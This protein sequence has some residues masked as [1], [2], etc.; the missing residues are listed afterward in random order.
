MDRPHLPR[1]IS[2]ANLE[3]TKKCTTHIERDLC[4]HYPRGTVNY[5]HNTPSFT[6]TIPSLRQY[7]KEFRDYV[8]RRLVDQ[9]L[10]EDLE[11]ENVINWCKDASTFIPLSTTGDGNCL[12]HAASLGMWGFQD[13]KFLLRRALRSALQNSKG[14]SLHARWVHWRQNEMK[15]FGFNLDKEEWIREW[16]NVIDNVSMET[17]GGVL[18]GLDQFHVF[19]LANVLRRP[20]IV[21]SLPK[22][23]SATEGITLQKLTFH[24]IYLPLLWD[25]RECKRIPLP[26]AFNGGHFVS[27]VA[28]D[29]AQQYKGGRLL[30]PLVEYTGVEFPVMFL[31]PDEKEWDVR[32]AYLNTNYLKNEIICVEMMLH[33]EPAYM[34]PLLSGFINKCLAAFQYEQSIVQT[35][36]A[37]ASNGGNSS[38]ANRPKCKN[39]CDFYGNPLLGGYCSVCHKKQSSSLSSSSAGLSLRC[40]NVGCT[41]KGQ[42]DLLG[43]CQ[44]CY[45]LK[46][47]GSSGDSA[48]KPGAQTAPVEDIRPCSNHGC[49]FIGTK[50]MSYYCSKCYKQRKGT[51]QDH[52][53]SK[54]PQTTYR[55]EF[56]SGIEDRRE[57][58]QSVSD[59]RNN[60]DKCHQCL[61]FYSSEEYSGL[62]HRCFIEKTRKDSDQRGN[63]IRCKK[64]SLPHDAVSGDL[65]NDCLKNQLD[66]ANIVSVSDPRNNPDKC[67]QCLEFYSSEEYSGLCHR[68]FIEKTR[69]DSDQRGNSIRC[70]KCSLPHDAVSGDLCNDCLK[71]Q[72]D[73]A[74]THPQGD[75]S[76]AGIREM[77]M[78]RQRDNNGNGYTPDHHYSDVPG[79]LQPNHTSPDPVSAQAPHPQSEL[80]QRRTSVSKGTCV[81]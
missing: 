60:P 16:D 68:C 79:H 31:L 63:S 77:D 61:E 74:K 66:A 17:K 38:A 78:T 21:Y 52:D 5:F 39:G 48:G 22:I 6:L 36:Q 51:S 13:R 71:N 30:L 23:R 9:R 64:C 47:T 25:P 20:I 53:D 54:R 57:R 1:S 4:E 80:Q 40:C 37:R 45:Q 56:V 46:Q 76:R 70:K 33:E 26:I 44:Q 27:L 32:R 55:Q 24:G 18:Q 8:F 10:K 58:R 59:P 62:C 11:I 65:C 75:V 35:N 43:M 3:T 73:A 12:L 41:K 29:S 81:L 7:P 49:E 42:P 2:S 67:H 34:K 14:N 50:E 15:A 72:L 28:I 19:T 69:K